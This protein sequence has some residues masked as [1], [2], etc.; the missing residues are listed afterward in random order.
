MCTVVGQ[1][2]EKLARNTMK[3]NGTNSKKIIIQ[4]KETIIMIKNLTL[5]KTNIKRRYGTGQSELHC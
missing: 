3:I 5:I 1:T 2:G 4:T